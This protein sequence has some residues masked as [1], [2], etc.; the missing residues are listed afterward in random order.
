MDDKSEKNKEKKK[1]TE[2]VNFCGCVYVYLPVFVCLRA[3]G[4]HKITSHPLFAFTCLL[5]LFETG[6]F[7]GLEPQ[8]SA[9]PLL[10]SAEIKSAGHHTQCCHSYPLA[11]SALNPTC[12]N[13]YLLARSACGC[14]TGRSVYGS[15]QPLS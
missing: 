8:G 14:N 15:E 2:P 1:H 5:V 3:Y 7:T 10:L 4:G 12:C 6:F 9:C 11:R 13:S